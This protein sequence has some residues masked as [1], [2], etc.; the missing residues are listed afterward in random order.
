M[1]LP[2]LATMGG[3]VLSFFII[4]MLLLRRIAYRR[5]DIEKGFPDA[6]D[7]LLICVEAG[8]GLDQAI[9]HVASELQSSYTVLAD[10]FG[11]VV[12]EVLAGKERSQALSDLS[13]RCDIDDVSA[14]VTVIKQSDKYGVS[15]ADTLRVYAAEMR[16]KRFLRAEEKASL[17][18]VKLALGAIVF[19]VP[20]V[21]L[22]LIGPSIVMIIREM[23]KAAGQ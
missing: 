9:A 18:P 6:L 14:F 21:I 1:L 17:M 7:L 2:I 23:A 11:T 5:L 15:I 8:N 16:D 20:P 12:A 13:R 22:I 4:D 10:E 19:T 3:V